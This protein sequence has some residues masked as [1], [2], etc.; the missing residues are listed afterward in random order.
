VKNLVPEKKRFSYFCLPAMYNVACMKIEAQLRNSQRHSLIHIL[1]Q[2]V[3]GLKNPVS[4]K[5]RICI[6]VFAC[7]NVVQEC[8]M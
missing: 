6:I 1:S 2:R 3:V 8:T 4:E 5:Q 7:Y